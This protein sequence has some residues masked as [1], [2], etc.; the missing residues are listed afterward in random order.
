MFT[1]EYMQKMAHTDATSLEQT[2]LCLF[3]CSRAKTKKALEKYNNILNFYKR[4]EA[5][6]PEEKLQSF[7]T[8]VKNLEDKI[9]DLNVKYDKVNI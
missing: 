1:Y 4:Q 7:N 8:K 3:V 6:I 5:E 9:K 2:G